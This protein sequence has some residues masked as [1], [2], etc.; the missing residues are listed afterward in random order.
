ML[1]PTDANWPYPG[2]RF[3]LQQFRANIRNF[4]VALAEAHAILHEKYMSLFDEGLTIQPLDCRETSDAL[5]EMYALVQE[6]NNLLSDETSIL[7]I[8]TLAPRYRLLTASQIV[9]DQTRRLIDLLDSYQVM[10]L[11][12][13]RQTE[14]M[15]NRIRELFQAVL[16]YI[17]DIPRQTRYLEEESKSLEQELMTSLLEEY[18]QRYLKIVDP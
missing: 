17:S 11:K 12:P 7:P 5:E 4:L 14:W 10:C 1:G 6:C 3:S 9:L 13:S 16:K 8:A 15:Y 18:T 2:S